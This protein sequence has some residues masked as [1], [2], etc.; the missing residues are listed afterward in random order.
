MK[1]NQRYRDKAKN[2]FAKSNLFYANGSFLGIQDPTVFGFK[3]FF[4]FDNISSPLLYGATTD[5]NEAPTN[6]AAG[7]LKSI[8]DE[9]RLYYLEKFL[10]LLSGVNSQTPWYFQSLVGLKDAW[11][12]PIDKPYMGDD[13]KL[14][15]ECMESIDLRMTALMDLYRK[16]CFDWKNRR[17][18]VPSNLRKFRLSVYVYEAR[19]F[20]NPNSIANV[21]PPSGINAG[22]GGNIQGDAARTNAALVSRLIGK[23]E[24]RNDP[25]TPDVNIVAGT[26][27]ST[28]RNLFHFDF[29]EFDMMQASH[30]DTVSNMEPGEVKQKIGI[31]YQDYEEEN[32]YNFWT[33]TDPI[34]S[35][36]VRTLDRV[37]LDDPQFQEPGVPVSSVDRPPINNSPNTSTGQSSPGG[38]IEEVKA[39]GDKNKSNLGRN[40][41]TSTPYLEEAGPDGREKS[42]GGKISDAFESVVDNAENT[43]GRIGDNTLIGDT[44]TSVAD[45]ALGRAENFVNAQISGLFLGNIYGFSAGTLI[46]AGG[47]QRVAASILDAGSS[48]ANGESTSQVGSQI[49]DPSGSNAVNSTPDGANLGNQYE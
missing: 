21:E 48:I 46:G 6:T 19:V 8:K 12:A 47:A 22:Y 36:Y 41:F 18:V 10:Y 24:T 44:L 34:T 13:K 4:Q 30:L 3:L 38:D 15:I 23:D 45:Q 26:Q 43:T 37:A 25:N 9:Q 5:I 29:C 14:E 39:E 16:A 11:A 42:F 33:S 28:T 27:M 32:M 31:K 2:A 20:G 17:E 40:A 1:T 49:F 7:F 35:A